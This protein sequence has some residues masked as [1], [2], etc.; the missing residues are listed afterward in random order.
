VYYA[1]EDTAK[2]IT[3][4]LRNAGKY[5]MFQCYDTKKGYLPAVNAYP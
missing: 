4:S 2:K 3:D 1:A 5:Y